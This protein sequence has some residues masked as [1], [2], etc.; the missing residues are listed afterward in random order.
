MDLNDF[1]TTGR[2]Q[3]GRKYPLEITFADGKILIGH[4]R[5]SHTYT[6]NEKRVTKNI[7]FLVIDDMDG[8]RDNKMQKG[9]RSIVFDDSIIEKVRA[10]KEY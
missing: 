9:N 3:F 1:P 6:E 8:W 5:S 7:D 4:I 2:D 10:Y